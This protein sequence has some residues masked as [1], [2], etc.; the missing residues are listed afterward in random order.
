VPTTPEDVAGLL[1]TAL[2]EDDPT[3]LLIPKHAMRVRHPAPGGT[4]RL[5]FGRARIVREG[6]D[7]RL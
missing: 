2:H 6:T 7:V 4:V 3:L 5:G 1:W